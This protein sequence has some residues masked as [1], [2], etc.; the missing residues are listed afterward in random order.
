MFMH[1][2]RINNEPTPKSIAFLVPCMSSSI[3][4]ANVTSSKGTSTTREWEPITYTF[5]ECTHKRKSPVVVEDEGG[6]GMRTS[7]GRP[8]C[9]TI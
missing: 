6:G 7:C 2:K 1:R 3:W 9:T 5:L 8:R 4:S